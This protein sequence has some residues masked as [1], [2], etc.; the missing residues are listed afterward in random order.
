MI[1]WIPEGHCAVPERFGRFKCTLPAGPYF[2]IPLADNV[3]N[4]SSRKGEA[5]KENYLI[6]LS[7][8]QT[9]TDIYEF[10][11]EDHNAV[12]RRDGR[13]SILEKLFM[14]ATDSRL[15]GRRI[16]S[17]LFGNLLGRAGIR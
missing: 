1:S 17:K 3:K 7:E 5:C 10:Q 14:L 11:T 9:F 2:Y 13:L 12:F 8:R 16:R 6:E 4:L 15:A